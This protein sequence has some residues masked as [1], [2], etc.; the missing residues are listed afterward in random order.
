LVDDREPER[1]IDFSPGQVRNERRPGLAS[2]KKPSGH[3]SLLIKAPTLYGRK[4]Q[5]VINDAV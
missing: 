4:A 3:G 5:F 2:N 1:L